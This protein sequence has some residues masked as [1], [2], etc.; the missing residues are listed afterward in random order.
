M[1]CKYTLDITFFD[2]LIYQFPEIQYFTV[3]G[4][5]IR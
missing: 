5:V 3:F 2:L 4:K 1:L